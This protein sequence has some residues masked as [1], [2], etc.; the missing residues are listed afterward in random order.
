MMKCTRYY[1]EP[2]AALIIQAM[3]KRIISLL[4]K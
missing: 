4:K 2:K 3:K 1:V